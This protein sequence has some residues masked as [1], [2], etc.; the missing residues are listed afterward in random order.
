MNKQIYLTA[1]SAATIFQNAIEAAQQSGIQGCDPIVDVVEKGVTQE[2]IKAIRAYDLKYLV[3]S[4]N[5]PLIQ[6]AMLIIALLAE[7]EAFNQDEA[8]MIRIMTL[9][10]EGD[11]DPWVMLLAKTALAQAGLDDTAYSALLEIDPPITSEPVS[12]Q[13]KEELEVAQSFCRMARKDDFRLNI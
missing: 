4:G 10:E 9:N 5:V 2:S 1:V 8:V 3:A 11:S 6:G 7:P 12:G 13:E